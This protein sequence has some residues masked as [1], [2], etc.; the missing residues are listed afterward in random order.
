M[1]SKFSNVLGFLAPK[2]F[3]SFENNFYVPFWLLSIFFP[4]KLR[5]VSFY[6]D[7]RIVVF[8]NGKKMGAK[9]IGK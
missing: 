4:E 8:L 6:A 3:F 9:K 7:F 1:A 2:S 5:Y